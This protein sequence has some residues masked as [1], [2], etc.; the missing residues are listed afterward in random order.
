MIDINGLLQRNRYLLFLF[1]A[2]AL[3][4]ALGYGI[5]HRPGQVILTILPAPPTPA[6]TPSPTQ[7]PVQCHVVG[8]VRLPGVYAL[9]YPATIRDA[10]E[11]AGGALEGAD[12]DRINL[13]ALVEDHQ[14]VRIPRRSQ[15]NDLSSTDPA[16]PSAQ[17]PINVN[18]ADSELLQTLPG[19]GPVLADRIIQ[20]RTENGPFAS[21]GELIGVRGIGETTLMN[22]QDLIT[23]E[24]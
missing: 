24:P 6:P 3:A 23:V 16:N 20:H 19:I 2:L 17:A 21:T 14:Q 9:D 13:A 10:I 22:I 7:A 8:A 15:G 11:A 5:S 18:D 1:L 12:L 4:V